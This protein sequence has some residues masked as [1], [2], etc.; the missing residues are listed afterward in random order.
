MTAA[1]GCEFTVLSA[2]A[3]RRGD[4]SLRR[5]VV[6]AAAAS[7]TGYAVLVLSQLSVVAEFGVLLALSVGVAYGSA[8]FVVWATRTPGALPALSRVDRDE[9]LVGVR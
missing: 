4:R 8:V 1:V 5:A 2:E 3:A 6:L 7:A 9:R